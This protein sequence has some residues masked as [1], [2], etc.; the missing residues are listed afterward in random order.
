MILDCKNGNSSS[1]HV[2]IAVSLTGAVGRA[3]EDLALWN[4]ENII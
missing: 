4:P 2:I 1:V 3:S